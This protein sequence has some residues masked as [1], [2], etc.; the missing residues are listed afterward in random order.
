MGGL[1]NYHGGEVAA[2]ILLKHGCTKPATL[3]GP[4]TW[5]PVDRL[6]GFTDY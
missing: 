6:G 5:L 4:L 3:S 1:D 2:E